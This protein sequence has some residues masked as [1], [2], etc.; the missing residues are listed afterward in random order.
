MRFSRYAQNDEY[1]CEGAP[2][3]RVFITTLNNPPPVIF[4]K[5]E[6]SVVPTNGTY[7][8]VKFSL[9]ESEILLLQSEIRLFASEIF[10]FGK[11]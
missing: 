2:L 4:E 3:D 10:A 11:S 9:V 8:A 1:S 5:V 7:G 6:K